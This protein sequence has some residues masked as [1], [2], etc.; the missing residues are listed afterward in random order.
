MNKINYYLNQYQLTFPNDVLSKFYLKTFNPLEPI[1]ISGN[2]MNGFYLLVEGKYAVT[3][4]E[5]TGKQLLLRFCSPLSILGDIEWFQK[6]SIQSDVIAESFC[7][8]VVI[9]F[10]VYVS[11]LLQHI[12][13]NQMLLKDLSYKLKTCTIA[14]RVNTLASVETRF[15]AYLCTVRSE[16]SYGKQIFTTKLHEMASLIGTTSR[17]LNRV[18]KKWSEAEI[19]SR[20][21]DGILINDWVEIERL[22]ENIRY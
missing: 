5:V 20:S 6:V 16:T 11:D 13:F 8:F 2:E 10:E 1:L 3:T 18:V 4:L 19:I 14:S 7:V 21:D 12:E 9:P 22:S 15:A 17:H